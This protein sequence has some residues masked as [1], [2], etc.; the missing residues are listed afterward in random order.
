MAINLKIDVIDNGIGIDPHLKHKV[1]EKFFRVSSGNIHTV[2]GFGLGLSFVKQVIHAHRGEVNL[3]SE[4]NK[5]T[6]VKIILP[7]A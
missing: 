3:L 1:F 6:E 5:G 7:K 2:K 4:L